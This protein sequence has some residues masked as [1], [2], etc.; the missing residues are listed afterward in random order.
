MTSHSGHSPILEVC[1]LSVEFPLRGRTVR[2]VNECNLNVQPGQIL[3]L[4]GESGSGKSITALACLGLVPTPGQVYGSVR[5]DGREIAACTDEELNQLRGGV[6]AMIFQNPVTALN[7]YFTVRR[8]LTDVIRVHRGLG[9]KAARREAADVF[10]RVKLPD[11]QAQLDKYPHQLSGGQ[12]QR[13]MIAMALACKPKILIADEPTTAL[14]V[15]VQAQ[16]IV[17]LRELAATSGLAIL[18]ITHDLGVV[19]STC[20]D[21]AV[22]YAGGIV[23]CGGVYDVFSRPSHPYTRRLLATVPRLG[24]GRTEFTAIPGQVPDLAAIPSGCPF[25]PRCELATAK[26]RD[27]SPDT[28]QVRSGHV[29]KCHHIDKVGQ[30]EFARGQE[31]AG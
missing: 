25:H 17:L 6:A 5:V 21:V 7:P 20:N 2:A 22:M 29:A 4:V 14:D 11:P 16:I 31:R 19:S 24:T 15:T 13:V 26:C 23:E 27:N 1:D 10:G 28:R 12:L 3:G 18:L 30:F 8:Q 9:G